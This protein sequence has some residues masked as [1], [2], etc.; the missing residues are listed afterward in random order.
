V[1][2]EYGLKVL[3][4][5]GEYFQVPTVGIAV[6]PAYV[7]LDSPALHAV[8]R[9]NRRALNTIVHQADVT[10]GHMHH[11]FL[12]RHTV[13][14]VR[15]HYEKFIAPYFSDDGHVELQIGDDAINAVAE[16][17]DV[18]TTFSAAEMYRTDPG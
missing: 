7:P 18:P 2:D 15:S 4:W 1:A 5:I 12:G 17:L 14:E 10:V 11:G 8:V 13:D 3:G 9:A 6:D 16:E